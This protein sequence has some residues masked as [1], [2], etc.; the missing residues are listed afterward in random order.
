MG[1]VCKAEGGRFDSDFFRFVPDRYQ[2]DA[3]FA[4]VLE[5]TKP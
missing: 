5:R 4:K 2:A 3:S 1:I